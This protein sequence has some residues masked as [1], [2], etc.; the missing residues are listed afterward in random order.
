MSTQGFRTDPGSCHEF[1]KS[2]AGI[3]TAGHV[4][5]LLEDLYAQPLE[6]Y[7]YDGD[8]SDDDDDGNEKALIIAAVAA[9]SLDHSC[10]CCQKQ[11]PWSQLQ[12]LP[13]ALVTIAVN[14]INLGHDCSCSNTP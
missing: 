6:V 11:K 10:N 13:K 4:N 3:Y 5:K 12:L 9:K 7:I 2:R 1:S 8:E 14:A